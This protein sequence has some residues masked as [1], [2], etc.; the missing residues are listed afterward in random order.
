MQ[1]ALRGFAPGVE[2]EQAEDCQHGDDAGKAKQGVKPEQ[3][4]VLISDENVEG[5]KPD[6]CAHGYDSEFYSAETLAH[7]QERDDGKDSCVVVLPDEAVA[8]E[9]E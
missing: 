7:D 2:Q 5:G 1:A 8:E 3:M 4:G 6:D 9:D